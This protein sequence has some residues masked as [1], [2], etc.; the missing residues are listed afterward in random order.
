MRATWQTAA[1]RPI[2]QRATGPIV[3]RLA[4]RLPGNSLTHSHPADAATD[5]SALPQQHRQFVAAVYDAIHAYAPDA[6]FPGEVVLFEATAEPARSGGGVAKRWAKIASNLTVVP[7][8]G[9]H[10]SI[11][12]EPDGRPLARILGQ[13]LREISASQPTKHSANLTNGA[14]TMGSQNYRGEAASPAG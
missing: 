3:R 14:A 11:V 10:M 12:M 2:W 4:T 6:D 9:T 7:V 8:K 1:F 13:K 5:T